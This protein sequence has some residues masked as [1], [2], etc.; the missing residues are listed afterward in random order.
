MLQWVVDILP[1]VG[2]LFAVQDLVVVSCHVFL[3]SI[4]RLAPSVSNQSRCKLA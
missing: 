3:F 2:F 1:A 4:E